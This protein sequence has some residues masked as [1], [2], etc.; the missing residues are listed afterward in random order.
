MTTEI[1]K[2]HIALTFDDGPNEHTV[3]ILDTFKKHGGH[4]TF[5]VVGN[6]IEGKED[7]LFRTASEGHEIGNHTFSHAPLTYMTEEDM[8]NDILKTTESIK[9]ACGA[10]PVFVRPPFGDIGNTV[11]KMGKDLGYAFAGWSLDTQDWA[12]DC[13]ENVIDI[14]VSNVKENDIILCHDRCLSTAVAME[15]I[16]P[17]L[18]D[19]GYEL[20][21]LSKLLKYN[22]IVPE[23]GEYYQNITL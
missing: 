22:G 19:M 2:K 21:T 6:T 8:K 4:G 18:I 5:F 23:K 12:T 20:V 14:I 15:K 7:I 10:A 3:N 9:S 16:I 11:K 17:A 1:K 13:P